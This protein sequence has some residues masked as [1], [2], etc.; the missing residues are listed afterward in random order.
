[1]SSITIYLEG[2]GTGAD[3]K[4]ALRRGMDAFL[5]PIKR[6]ARERSW[7]WNLVA[8]G[9]RD[10]AFRRFR[11]A[12][13]A[14]PDDTIVLL[15]DAETGIGNS[16]PHEHLH[17]LDHWNLAFAANETVHLMV[18]IMETWIIADTDA[19]AGYYGP[20]FRAN[21]LPAA[22]QLETVTKDN[23]IGGLAQ[24][25]HRTQK[26]VYHKIRHAS[27]LLKRIDP[28]KVRQRCPACDRFFNTLE[29][30]ITTAA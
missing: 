6:K 19:L 21:A 29:R 1:M 16:T 14:R 20:H 24:A 27:E 28:Q 30:W 11:D 4:S 12:V 7:R 5:D 23:I 3:T 15:V 25:T 2:G 8:C 22:G 26:G 18:Q 9:G 17:T 13:A 10:Q